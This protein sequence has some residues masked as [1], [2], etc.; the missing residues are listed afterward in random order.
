MAR[1]AS[2][3]ARAIAPVVAATTV[4]VLVD[5]DW[6]L[7]L[8]DGKE[9]VTTGEGEEDREDESCGRTVGEEVGRF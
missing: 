7:A 3:M 6:G 1:S 4:P 2:R 9:V 5:L 8:N